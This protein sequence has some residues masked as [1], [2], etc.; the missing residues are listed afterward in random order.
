MV[1]RG[2]AALSWHISFD[3]VLLLI[4]GWDEVIKRVLHFYT[5]W[6][7]FAKWGCKMNKWTS[8]GKKNKN[9]FKRDRKCLKS[10]L[11]HTHPYFTCCA[12]NHTLSTLSQVPMD[13]R[14]L[15]AWPSLPPVMQQIVTIQWQSLVLKRRALEPAAALLQASRLWTGT[16][17]ARHRLKGH[18]D[19][20]RAQETSSPG[21]LRR[22]TNLC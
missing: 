1:N 13:F 9:E 16:R 2:K 21:C 19:A 10:C 20:S 6:A 5:T 8:W 7:S 12:K 22:L 4:L 11:P 15:V 17:Q 14:F 18:A 3:L